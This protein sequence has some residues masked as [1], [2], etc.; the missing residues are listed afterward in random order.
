MKIKKKV[1][2]YL[3]KQVH[4]TGYQIKKVNNFI[5]LESILNKLLNYKSEIVFIQIGGNDGVNDDPLHHFINLN[6]DRVFGYIL[7]P[8]KDYFDEL[9]YNYRAF[10]NINTLNLAVHNTEDVM[11]INRVKPESQEKLPKYTKGIASFKNDHHIHCKVASE[12][13]IKESVKCITLENLIVDNGIRTIDLLQI[14]TEGYDAEIIL[15]IDFTKCK[16]S[17]INFEYYIP[18]TMR[19]ETFENILSILHRNGYEIWLDTNDVTA[20]QRELFIQVNK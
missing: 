1:I 2:Y 3:K 12:H 5:F 20:Y 10:P 15:N 14:D 11:L 6:K 13:I 19:K 8:V 4:K 9:E 16:P 17:I 7:E 18:N